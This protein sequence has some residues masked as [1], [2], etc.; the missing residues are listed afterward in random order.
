MKDQAAQVP[1][2]Q[3]RQIAEFLS[4]RPMGSDEA[5]DI[6]KMTNPCPANPP[7]DGSGRRSV[8]ER[9]ESRRQERTVSKRER[10]RNHRRSNPEPETEMGFRCSQSRRNALATDVASGRVFFGSDAGYIYSLDAKTGCV[11]W[12][13]HAD[14]GYAHRSNHRTD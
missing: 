12:A 5:G 14:S 2:V 10:S 4:G 7:I 8:L 1:D 9:L 6:K 13:F 3:K 11:Y